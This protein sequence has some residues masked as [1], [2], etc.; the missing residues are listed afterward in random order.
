MSVL[1]IIKI[2][3]KPIQFSKIDTKAEL[4]EAADFVLLDGNL[5]VEAIKRIAHWAQR[6]NTKSAIS[7]PSFIFYPFSVWFE[8][9]NALKVPK[10]FAAFGPNPLAKVD[11]F[12]PNLAELREF[13]ANLDGIEREEC[14]QF[15]DNFEGPL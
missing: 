4:I 7:I 15:V 11:I 1:L 14:T 8:P 2:K 6:G 3:I 10:L 5:G 13:V 12:S 9:T